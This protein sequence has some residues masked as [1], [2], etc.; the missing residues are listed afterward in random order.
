MTILPRMNVP[1]RS[2]KHPWGANERKFLIGGYISQSVVCQL[3]K[4]LSV[5]LEKN[6]INYSRSFAFICGK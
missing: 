1:E 2:D 3:W 5:K 4:V 6:N